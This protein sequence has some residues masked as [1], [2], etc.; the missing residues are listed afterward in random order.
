MY[1]K[2][3]LFLLGKQ[4]HYGEIHRFVEIAAQDGHF[5]QANRESDYTKIMHN[6][7]HCQ[8]AVKLYSV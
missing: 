4:C 2:M 3:R 1:F 7:Y 5:F 8:I 6:I